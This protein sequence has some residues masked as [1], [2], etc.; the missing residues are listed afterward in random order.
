[1]ATKLQR[2]LSLAVLMITFSV[3]ASAEAGKVNILQ[4]KYASDGVAESFKVGTDWYPFPA[5][6]DR[7]AWVEMMGNDNVQQYIAAGEKYLGFNW[8]HITAATF[9]QPGNSDEKGLDKVNR[10]AFISLA[11]AELAEGKGRFLNDIADGYWFY[12]TSEHWY[13]ASRTSSTVPDLKN[14]VLDL[15]SVRASSMLCSFWPLFRDELDALDP[16]INTTFKATVKRLILDPFLNMDYNP[17]WLGGPTV[18]RR[19][20]NWTPWC[21]CDIMLSFFVIENDQER[22]HKAL[23]RALPAVDEFLGDIPQDGLCEEGPTY[24][25]HSVGRTQEF[26]CLL[27]DASGGKFDIL[28]NEFISNMGRFIVKCFMGKGE[29]G[30]NIVANY[31]DAGPYMTLD[32]YVLW[33]CAEGFNLPELKNLALYGSWTGKKFKT[34]SLETG[35]GYKALQNAKVIK[36][37]MKEISKLNYQVKSGEAVNYILYDLQEKTP[38][39]AWYPLGQQCFIKTYDGWSFSA[40]AS[41]NAES[42]NHND[43]GSCILYIDN[44]P[45]FVDSGTGSYGPKTFG[46]ER[47]TIWTMQGEW[48]NVPMINGT[49]QKAGTK[50]RTTDVNFISLK[51]KHVL[52]CDMAGAYPASSDCE[53][54]IRTYSLT[55]KRKVSQLEITDTYVLKSRNASDVEHF[56]IHG[57]AECVKPGVV[58]ISSQG[59]RFELTYPSD[60]LT[61]SIDVQTDLNPGLKKYWGDSLTRINLTSAPDAPLS[62]TYTLKLRA[63]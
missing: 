43:S 37:I 60:L 4:E 48:H 19:L 47:Y 41:F 50:Y 9:L 45:V 29:K 57:E 17:W 25:F 20:N 15:S 6:S 40:K 13:K 59:R 35:E 55:T 34:P 10:R 3:N 14:Y 8:H 33:H 63:L 51:D 18:A 30:K 31:G 27:Y 28:P 23:G 36:D 12:S 44:I 61:F 53:S 5:Y 2:L 49:A 62:G 11:M 21:C 7:K 58:I 52:T 39:V 22:L 24:W 46:P 38:S 16:Q 1:M 42:H 56:L 32:P 26:L 54:W